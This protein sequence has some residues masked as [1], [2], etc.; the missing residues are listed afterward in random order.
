[1][2]KDCQIRKLR[3]S[4]LPLILKWRNHPSIRQHMFTQHEIQPEEHAQWYAISSQDTSKELCL[5]EEKGSPIGYVQF[6]DVV[7]G[8]SSLWGFYAN[9]DAPKGTG[10]KLA[11]T[12]LSYAF[13]KLKLY[14][15]CGEVLETNHASQVFH[16]KLGFKPGDDQRTGSVIRY[17][18]IASDWFSFHSNQEYSNADH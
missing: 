6:S 7:A 18:L 15:V 1:M 13:T 8:G 2:I 3:A 17:E 5:V 10:T 16:E 14:K 11:Q 12:A 9:P 4:D